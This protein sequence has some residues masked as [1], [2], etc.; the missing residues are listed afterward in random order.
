MGGLAI[1]HKAE[2]ELARWS[3]ATLAGGGEEVGVFELVFTAA[4]TAEREAEG[5]FDGRVLQSWERRMK[6]KRVRRC[7]FVW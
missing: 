1:L 2:A 3:G 6:E 7:T 4:L 5:A